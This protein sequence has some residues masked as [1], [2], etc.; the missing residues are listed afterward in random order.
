[1]LETKTTSSIPVRRI[2]QS[3]AILLVFYLALNHLQYGVEKSAPIDAYCPFGGLET[4]LTLLLT[5]SFVQR[6]YWAAVLLAVLTVVM[7]VVFGRAFCGYICPFGALQE[8]IRWLGRKMGLKTNH[9]PPAR[10]DKYI[11]YLKYLVLVAVIY[12]SYTGS[13]LGFR[14]YDPYVALMHFGQET[15][16]VSIGL[17]VLVA[18]LVAALFSKNLWC[19]YLCP[20]GAFYGVFNGVKMFEIR[21]DN[22]GCIDC[23]ACNSVCPHGIDVQHQEKIK[24]ADCVSCLECA[25]SCP[26]R[27][28]TSSVGKNE[29]RNVNAFGFAVVGFFVFVVVS[30]MVLGLW[31]T[32]PS[33]NLVLTNGQI[34][35]AGI[36]GSNTLE[37]LI[38][39]TGL[40]LDVFS[41]E[42]SL[43]ADV[44]TSLQLREIGPRYNLK[45]NEGA[46]LE[47][48]DFRK[49]VAKRQGIAHGSE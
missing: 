12:L 29:V 5:G 19:R 7:T 40:P 33:S 3:L 43:P 11:R 39:T 2:T 24:D 8:G 36:R 47:T 45:K 46:P 31:K 25:A 44:D 18:V 42:L 34:D 20:L 26:A 21:R 27:C 4:A 17:I 49:V 10:A 14:P 16:A 35:V 28:L 48:E 15:E 9:E 13:Q 37:N 30:S 23:G 32:A 6:V 41:K 1:M 38:K 22:G